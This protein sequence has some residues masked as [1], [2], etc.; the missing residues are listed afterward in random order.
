MPKSTVKLAQV[1]MGYLKSMRFRYAVDICKY[2]YPQVPY[3]QM[4]IL[5]ARDF[6]MQKFHHQ[7]MHKCNLGFIYFQTGDIQLNNDKIQV[8]FNRNSGMIMSMTKVKE[9]ITIAVNMKFGS[10]SSVNF[11]SGA[12]LLMPDVQSEHE[13]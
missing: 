9:N 6:G 11:R 13:V 3:I 2:A 7:E 10:Y 4:L 8:L 1:Y 5:W 12:Y